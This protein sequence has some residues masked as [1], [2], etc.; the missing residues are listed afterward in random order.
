MQNLQRTTKSFLEKWLQKTVK[1]YVSHM[2]G[3]DNGH[4]YELILSG[5]EKPLVEIVLK[6]TGGNQTQAANILGINRN[7]LRKKIQEYDL[8]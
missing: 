1:Q 4:L 2:N 5:V 7:T 3:Q 6:E 8:Q